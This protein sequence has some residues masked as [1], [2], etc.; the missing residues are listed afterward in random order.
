MLI[1]EYTHTLDLKKRVSLPAKFRVVI[2]KKM[3]LAKGLD[4]CISVYTPKEWERVMQELPKSVQADQRNFK[5]F[6]TSGASEASLDSLGRILV[7]DFLKNYAK[8]KTKVVL[9]GV[10]DHIEIWDEKSWKTY[11]DKI[12]NSAEVLAEKL[13]EIGIV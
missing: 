1:G 4:H 11:R 3:V 2:G 6:M 9:A 13:G 5:R 10:G 8:L 7:P 12:E